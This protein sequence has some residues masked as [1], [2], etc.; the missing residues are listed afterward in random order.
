MHP[1]SLLLIH[2]AAH[3]ELLAELHA[4]RPQ[5]RT[6]VRRAAD[7]VARAIGVRGSVRRRIELT[8]PVAA[9]CLACA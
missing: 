8:D 3:A 1:E 9:A 6:R 7:A 2:H 4:S 5:G